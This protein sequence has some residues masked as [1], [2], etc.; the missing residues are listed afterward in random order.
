[1]NIENIEIRAY[2]FSEKS[3]WE[4]LFAFLREIDF[5]ENLPHCTLSIDESGDRR[6]T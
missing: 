1:M 6:L 4:K 3:E 2:V 5:E